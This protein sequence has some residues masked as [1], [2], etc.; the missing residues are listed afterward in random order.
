MNKPSDDW[1]EYGIYLE[2]LER[3]EEAI[4]SYD[5]ALQIEPNN[6]LVWFNRGIALDKWGKPEEAIASFNK[7]MSI[8]KE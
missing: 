8:G 7:S 2:S 3:Y 5:R 6:P 4:A 1:H